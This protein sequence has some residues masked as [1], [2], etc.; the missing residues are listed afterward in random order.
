MPPV[1]KPRYAL[2]SRA[3]DPKPRSRE[4]APRLAYGRHRGPMPKRV[5]RAATMVAIY[6]HPDL[7]WVVL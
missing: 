7:G 1:S 3:D 2:R 4:M 5:R 6:R